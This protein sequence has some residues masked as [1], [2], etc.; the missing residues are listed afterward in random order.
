MKRWLV[1]FWTPDGWDFEEV[2]AADKREA[3]SKVYR[4]FSMPNDRLV[5]QRVKE[6]A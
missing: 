2:S 1:W 4:W 3:A 5:E 6:L